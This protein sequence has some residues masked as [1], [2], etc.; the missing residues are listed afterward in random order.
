VDRQLEPA[1]FVAELQARSDALVELG[2]DALG[3]LYDLV[4][5]RLLRYAFLVVKQSSDAEDAVQASMVRIAMHP[6]LLRDAVHPWA[7]LLRIVR[8]ESLRVLRRRK[9]WLSFGVSADVPTVEPDRVVETESHAAIRA[10]VA[11]LPANQSEVIVLKIWEGLTFA[12]IADVLGESPNTVASRYRYAMEKLSQWLH[13]L[14]S[15]VKRD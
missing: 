12:E 15:E 10:A 6:K 4:A 3:S 11:R 5:P 2:V 1:A 7:Y 9:P 8:N 14:A 13:P